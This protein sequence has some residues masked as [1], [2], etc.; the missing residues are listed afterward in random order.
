MNTFYIYNPKIKVNIFFK[1]I[2]IFKS[3]LLQNIKVKIGLS[4]TGVANSEFNG[5]I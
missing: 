1:T 3:Q 2:K 4:R 5:A